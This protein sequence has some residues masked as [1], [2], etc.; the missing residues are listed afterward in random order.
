[1]CHLREQTIIFILDRGEEN[2]QNPNLGSDQA[3]GPLVYKKFGIQKNMLNDTTV[4]HEKFDKI[5]NPVHSNNKLQ[6]KR[7]G[8]GGL[9]KTTHG[10]HLDP[11]SQF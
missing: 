9:P 11:D 5:H 10:S 3:S 6:G 2:P 7:E 8:E 1:M 4:S